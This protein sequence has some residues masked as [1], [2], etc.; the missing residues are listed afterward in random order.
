M[1]KRERLR[2]AFSANGKEKILKQ[3][4]R[5]EDCRFSECLFD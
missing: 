1:N 4:A 2:Q 5:G 3:A